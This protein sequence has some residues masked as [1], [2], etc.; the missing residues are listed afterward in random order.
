MD[1]ITVA[2]IQLT[3]NDDKKRNIDIAV[4]LIDNAVEKGAELIVLPEMFN[5]YSFPDVMV[6]NAETIPGYT[7][8]ILA[9]K[10]R[11]KGVYIICGIYEKAD[12][13]GTFDGKAYNT[14]VAIS[15]DGNI[16][17]TYSKTHLF[18][19]DVPGSVTYMESQNV[20][21][22]KKITNVQI[23]GIK[24]GMAVCYDL[25]FPELFRV[26][27]LN[28]A[29][30]F[31]MP[32]AFTDATGRFHWDSLLKARAIENQTFLVAANQIGRHPNN[33]VSHGNSMI[34]DPWG[35]VLA[36]AADKDNIIIAQLDFKTLKKIREE[37][38][39]FRQRRED[40]YS[41][42]SNQFSE[43]VMTYIAL[44]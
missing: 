29:Q 30:I 10:A 31:A 2:A 44:H 7:T 18:D 4:G 9:R 27:A 20:A 16:L 32:C 37:M 38:P 35:R 17:D 6:R 22:G 1:K 42:T 13:Q 19:I 25:R 24:C 34:L 5:C 14:C 40:L 23:K 41:I 3:A 43:G 28:G 11:D 15:P 39:L 36:H 21:P 33:I 12:D 26:M 8:D